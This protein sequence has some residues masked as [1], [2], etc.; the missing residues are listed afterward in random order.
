MLG[1]QFSL[2]RWI[3]VRR[4]P[5]AF[6]AD[7]VFMVNNAGFELK[8]PVLGSCTISSYNTL[9]PF[10]NVYRLWFLQ[11]A[12]NVMLIRNTFNLAAGTM[13]FSFHKVLFIRSLRF[14]SICRCEMACFPLLGK[15]SRYKLKAVLYQLQFWKNHKKISELPWL[16]ES[17]RKDFTFLY[18]L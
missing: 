14:F 7:G 1:F 15:C 6:L 17:S 16:K 12:I 9:P 8:S 3:S 4:F 10:S 5:T 18:R 13:S 2:G 11:G